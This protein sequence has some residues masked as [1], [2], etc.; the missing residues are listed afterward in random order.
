VSVLSA[1]DIGRR[2][3]AFWAPKNAA[4]IVRRFF[5]SAGGSDEWRLVGYELQ[6]S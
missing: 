2:K 1:T 5:P 3:W 6:D 4:E